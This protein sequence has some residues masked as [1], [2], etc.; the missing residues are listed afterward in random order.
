MSII[1]IL[2]KVRNVSK[3]SV[4]VVTYDNVSKS[5]LYR[6]LMSRFRKPCFSEDPPPKV[7][8]GFL[9]CLLGAYASKSLKDESFC[10]DCTA[11]IMLC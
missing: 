9:R 8:S 5:T 3:S 2:T 7:V 4:V 6:S 1:S 11:A 10:R